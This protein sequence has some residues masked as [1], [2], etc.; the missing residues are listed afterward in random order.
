MHERDLAYVHRDLGVDR[1]DSL[2]RDQFGDFDG[3]SFQEQ[4][5]AKG[6]RL[7]DYGLGGSR[8]CGDMP[9]W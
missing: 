6:E 5:N 1:D 7:P 9:G 2:V 3:A 4:P 8:G